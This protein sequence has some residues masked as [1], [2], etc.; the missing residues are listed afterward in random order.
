[1]SN[2]PKTK[3]E[4]TPEDLARYSFKYFFV[5]ILGYKWSPHHNEWYDLLT[6]KKRVLIECARGHGKTLFMVAY[7]LW[8]VYKQNPV[9]ILFISHSEEQVK[10]NIMN[11]LDKLVMTNDYLTSLRPTTK[12]L[13]GAQLKTFASGASIRGESFGSSVRGAHPDYL[14]VDDPLKDKGGMSPE[15]QHQ[16]YMTALVGTAKQNTQIVVT[17]T[18]LDNGDLLEQLE[19]N[20]SYTFKAYPAENEDRT[21]ALFPELFSLET[22][23]E[24]EKEQ[25]SFAYSRERLLKRIDPK[26][27][28][29]KDQYRTINESCEFPD[30]ATVRTIVDP[31]ISEKEAACD[32]AVVTVGVDYKNN[33]WEMDTRLLQSDDPAKILGE[34]IKVASIYSK[35][36]AD[37][38]IV[39]EGELFQKVLAFDLRQKLIEKG[40][41]VRVIEVVHSGN[42]GKAQRIIGL[43][44]A[45]EARAIHL[46]PESPL[47]AQFRYYRPLAKGLKVDGIDAFS[48]IRHETVAMP[49]V[50]VEPIDGEVPPEAWD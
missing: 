29:F 49:V 19:K 44:A 4:F 12:Q 50:D 48:W 1:M 39:I 11:L 36:Y 26:T 8:L 23:R 9:E 5:R 22:L 45:W 35:K 14:F 28:V 42:T 34:I 33:F 6:T 32:S 16:Y 15:E 7:A 27:A 47:I 25:G 31:A 2:L 46:I 41:D 18:P 21:Q 13:W 40:L 17:G 3:T 20:E 30:L 10:N 24:I 43:Q 37:Y 38:A